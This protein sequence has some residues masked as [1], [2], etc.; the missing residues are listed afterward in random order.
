MVKQDEITRL[1]HDNGGLVAERRELQR[2]VQ[3]G[4]RQLLA[5]DQALKVSQETVA[6]LRASLERHGQEL[7]TMQAREHSLQ[8]KL[9]AEQADHKATQAALV[10]ALSA[11]AE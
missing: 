1:T 2:Q 4:E 10:K 9:E 6:D 3:G 5:L 11:P 8:G 7:A